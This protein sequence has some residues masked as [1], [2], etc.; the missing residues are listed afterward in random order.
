M[1]KFCAF[2]HS[3]LCY[4]ILCYACHFFDMFFSV[5]PLL[6]FLVFFLKITPARDPK[7]CGL[8]KP[9]YQ[10]QATVGTDEVRHCRNRSIRTFY[11]DLYRGS[12][13]IFIQEPPM[14]ISEE[15]SDKHQSRAS[16]KS[17]CKDI[18]RRI[19]TGS[20]QDLLTRTCTRS[21]KDFTRT[22]SKKI[23]RICTRSCKSLR[24]HL[25]RTATRSSH[26]EL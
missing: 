19:S 11:I 21:C 18:S 23:T 25:T 10:I 15:L 5:L 20:P 4:A 8:R 22:S 16:S 2:R 6:S 1:H 13:K 17:L 24:Q 12:H 7:Q 3:S 9:T 14:S 26:K